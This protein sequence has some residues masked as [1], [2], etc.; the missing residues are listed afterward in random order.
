VC[1]E[2]VIGNKG[3]LH[4]VIEMVEPTHQSRCTGKGFKPPKGAAVKSHGTERLGKGIVK[5]G[6]R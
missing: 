2:A 1:R 6:I 4:A 5:S 3:I